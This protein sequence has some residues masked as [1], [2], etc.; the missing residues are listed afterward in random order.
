[1]RWFYLALCFAVAVAFWLGFGMPF[2]Q[3]AIIGAICGALGWMRTAL[4][5]E[6]YDH[7]EERREA[8]EDRRKRTGL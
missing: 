6:V 1:M 5:S 3:A 2:W 7:I 8:R 4:M